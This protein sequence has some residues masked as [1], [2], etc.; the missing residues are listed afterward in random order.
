MRTVAVLADI[1]LGA[2]RTVAV[3]ADI[4]L[5][6]LRT[7]AVLADIAL[8]ALR[9][10]AVL[11]VVA[12]RTLGALRAVGARFAVR[13]IAVA[14]RRGALFLAVVFVAR[15]MVGASHLIVAVTV[16]V[17]ARPALI[18]LLETRAAIFQNAEIMIGELEV[19]FGLDA[20]PSELHV[21]R[22]SFI[23]LEQLG[24]IAALAIVL[25]IAVRA[26]GSIL[27]TLSTATA[28]APAL[29]IVDQESCSLSHR[30]PAQSRTPLKSSFGSDSPRRGDRPAQKDAQVDPP[31]PT[32]AR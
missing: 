5:G 18:L 7:V 4:A 30:A 2:L 6:A 3:L 19:I 13:A 17:I 15:L 27:G 8:G 14:A 31:L 28:T 11:A 16:I 32:V 12:L 22:Q 25:A 21:A 29:T 1:A 10:V 23:L 26:A 24:G 9:T 20:I